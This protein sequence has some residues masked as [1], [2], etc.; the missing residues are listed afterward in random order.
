MDS[1]L[2][3][4]YT[5]NSLISSR[6]HDTSCQGRHNSTQ[7]SWVCWGYSGENPNQRSSLQGVGKS[8]NL[9]L[10]VVW[11]KTLK[12]QLTVTIYHFPFISSVF[13]L[14]LS[15]SSFPDSLLPTHFIQFSF[16]G[17]SCC[18]SLQHFVFLLPH[19]P[20]NPP[21][22]EAS[23]CVLCSQTVETGINGVVFQVIQ[24]LIS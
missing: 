24:L 13:Y 8:N 21:L 22:S 16:Y 2:A 11:R 6:C 3:G 19:F 9:C 23:T 18:S 10:S 1:S 4:L 15:F 17:C 12:N 5:D 14:T 7:A 20:P